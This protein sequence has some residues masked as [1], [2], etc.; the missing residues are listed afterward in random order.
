MNA[1]K[2]VPLS[3]RPTETRMAEIDAR[4]RRVQELDAREAHLLETV[5]RL[6]SWETHSPFLGR[7]AWDFGPGGLAVNKDVTPQGD[8]I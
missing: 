1:A 7:V 5:A 4:A 8:H 6:G 2:P 3:F